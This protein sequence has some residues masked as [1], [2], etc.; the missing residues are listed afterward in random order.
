[1]EQGIRLVTGLSVLKMSKA[2]ATRPENI[3]PK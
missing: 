2:T 3:I 1:M